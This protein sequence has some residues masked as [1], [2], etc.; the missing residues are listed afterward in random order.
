M[1]L[2]GWS[3]IHSLWWSTLVGIAAMLWLGWRRETTPARRH[4]AG[5]LALALMTI[6]PVLIAMLQLD[7]MPRAGRMLVTRSVD[8]AVG[9]A[10][11]LAAR[12]EAVPL[13]AG[14]WA[15][16]AALGLYR[17]AQQWRRLSRDRRDATP[18]GDL[19]E[20]VVDLAARLEIR[21]PVRVAHS[22]R[23]GVPMVFG[24]RHPMILLPSRIDQVL[25]PAQLRGILTHELAHVRRQDF[26]MNLVQIGLDI[27]LWFHPAARWVSRQVRAERE[28][29]CDDIALGS[30]ANTSTYA[31]ALA[32]LDDARDE[33]R[34]AIAAA[35][36]T[37]LDRLER[38]TGRPRRRLS[39]ATGACVALA[40]ILISA[41][42]FAA[43]LM[44]PPDV[45]LDA[46]LRQRSPGPTVPAVGGPAG[47]RTP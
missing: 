35:S 12:R 20:H 19:A 1:A 41:A 15:L 7:P 38:I 39:P 4:T 37:L 16:G 26:A 30:G 27:V 21:Q 22:R 24:W 31:H 44:I 28:F 46:Q 42:A 29:C 17:V 9:F 47:P 3:V 11:F 23:C 14:L 34:L 32:A 6:G 8:E 13:V 45:A 40:A 10:T 18:A 5:L 25:P 33:S 43:A 2:I 36:G